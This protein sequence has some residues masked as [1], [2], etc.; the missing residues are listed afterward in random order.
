M[1]APLVFSTRINPSEIDK[2]AHNVDV[3]SEYPLE[4]YHAAENFANPKDLEKK[5]DTV[6][7]RIGTPAQY[8]G[9]GFTHDT[10]DIND[11]PVKSVYKSMNSMVEKME[12]EFKLA[13]K[14]IGV[15]E[16]DMARRVIE[17]HFLPDII[18]NMNSFSKQSFRCVKC[19]A[20]ISEKPSWGLGLK[21]QRAG[22]DPGMY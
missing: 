19:I 20:S 13:N 8:Q 15:D 11:G 10:T 22:R 9:F 17:S 21:L 6:G 1:D 3:G 4:L 7:G 16:R 18:G 14:L 2:E 5:M 12:A